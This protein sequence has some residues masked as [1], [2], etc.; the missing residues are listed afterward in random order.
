MRFEH[1]LSPPYSRFHPSNFL[2]HR[3]V[4]IVTATVYADAHHIAENGSLFKSRAYG[5][6]TA[7]ATAS[8]TREVL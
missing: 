3:L 2:S 5:A 4:D 7:A 6:M 1:S 8:A